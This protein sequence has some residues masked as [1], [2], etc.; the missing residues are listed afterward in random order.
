[1]NNAKHFLFILLLSPVL[2][3]AQSLFT[4]PEA[5]AAGDSDNG[6]GTDGIVVEKVYSYALPEPVKNGAVFMTIKNTGAES[7]F[8]VKATAEIADRVEL[9]T[10]K[11]VEG[12]MQMREVEKI[13]IPAG[14]AHSLQPMG[15][16]VMIFGLKDPLTSGSNFSMTLHFEKAGP[17]QVVVKVVDPGS[18]P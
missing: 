10:H 13:E 5:L 16:H 2:L 9:H 4:S 7:D 18:Q 8:L 11:H 12:I 6:N 17:E 15:D 1:M 14:K 3:G